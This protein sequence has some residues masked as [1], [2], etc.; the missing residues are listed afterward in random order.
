MKTL[1]WFADNC[2]VEL[3]FTESAILIHFS[4]LPSLL[5][6]ESITAP[7]PG[8]GFPSALNSSL[9]NVNTFLKS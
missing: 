2:P 1:I 5:D 6:N 8:T 4:I 9:K 7:A 3:V